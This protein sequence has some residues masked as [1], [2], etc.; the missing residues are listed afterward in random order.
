VLCMDFEP[1]CLNVTWGSLLGHQTRLTR[2][3][4][5]QR[6]LAVHFGYDSMVPAQLP[7]YLALSLTSGEQRRQW[8]EEHS[9]QD[10][11]SDTKI[12]L[13]APARTRT[14][15]TSSTSLCQG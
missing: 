8:N 1:R 2:R 9:T 3:P 12:T 10:M 5:S 11:P 14:A 4:G 6:E 7:G 15:T 13:L